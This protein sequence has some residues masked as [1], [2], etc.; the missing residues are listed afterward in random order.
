MIYAALAAANP[1][2]GAE[3]AELEFGFAPRRGVEEVSM[4]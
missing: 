2:N 3:I 4:L 1:G